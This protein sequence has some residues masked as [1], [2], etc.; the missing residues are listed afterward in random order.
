MEIRGRGLTR[1][2]ILER[3]VELGK[4]SSTYFFNWI[5]KW[6]MKILCIENEVITDWVTEFYSNMYDADEMGFPPM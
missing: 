4:F 5:V 1:K 6:H 3:L 2:I